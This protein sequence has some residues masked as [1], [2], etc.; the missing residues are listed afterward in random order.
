M[1]R[2]RI[3]FY[4]A[5]GYQLLQRSVRTRFQTIDIGGFWDLWFSKPSSGEWLFVQVGDHTHRAQKLKDAAAWIDKHGVVK[6]TITGAYA[7]SH[8][9]Y[10]VDIYQMPHWEGRGKSKRY[11]KDTQ[12]EHMELV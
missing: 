8:V 3:A 6:L 2:E 1:E 4:E 11:I 5:L 12:W 9:H 7:T 10:A